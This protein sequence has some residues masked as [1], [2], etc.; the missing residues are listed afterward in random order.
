MAMKIAIL[1]DNSERVNAMR[2]RLEERFYTFQTAFFDTAPGMIEFLE[3]HLT[4]IILIGLDHDLELIPSP[5]GQ[6]IDP[7]TGR[8]VANFLATKQ[9]A[10]PVIIQTTNTDAAAGMERVLRGAGWK[11]DRVIP[12]NDLEWVDDD[13]FRTVRRPIV[14]PEGSTR[15]PAQA[16]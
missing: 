12:C 1:E 2:R 9:P 11:T 13:W 16:D 3:R 7:G 4:E 5:T 6:S 10:C 14:R 15:S 8:D